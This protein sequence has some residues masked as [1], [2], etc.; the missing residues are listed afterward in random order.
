MTEY[1]RCRYDQ[2]KT[3]LAVVQEC[4]T[5]QPLAEGGRLRLAA[6]VGLART[7][8]AGALAVE[9]VDAG[10]PTA[11]SV[12]TGESTDPPSP[13]TGVISGGRCNTLLFGVAS[14]GGWDGSAVV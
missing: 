2:P 6:Q 14:S 13:I 12:E 8:F 4:A 10:C 1:E 7:V 9:A 11:S 5:T 3:G